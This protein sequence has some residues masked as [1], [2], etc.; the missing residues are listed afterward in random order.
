MVTPIIMLTLMLMPYLVARIA[1]TV[2]HYSFDLRAAAALGLGIL[3]IFTGVGHFILTESMAQMMSPWVPERTL[4]VYLTGGLEFVIAAGFFIPK[5]RRLSGWAAAVVLILFF[6]ANIYA[7]INQV[8]MGGHAWGLTYLFVRAP[9]QIVILF[10][11]YWFTI[12]QTQAIRNGE[13]D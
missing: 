8:P 7:A 6:P 9:L 12:R 10:W 4:I 1:S 13:S 2:T 3:F 5:T 11:V